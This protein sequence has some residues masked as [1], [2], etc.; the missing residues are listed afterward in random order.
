MRTAAVVIVFAV[1][2]FTRAAVGADE[3]PIT[4]DMALR[5]V[6]GFREADPRSDDALGYAAIAL[7]FVR[8]DKKLQFTL[9]P[10]NT[11]FVAAK[12]LSQ[13]Q[14]SLLLGA[15]TVGNLQSCL[16]RGDRTD[17]PYAGDLQVIQTYRQ[18]QKGQPRLRIPEIE[19]LIE[20]EDRG[21]L[22]KYV[23]SP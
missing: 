19:K 8:K 15:Y 1:A 6:A 7:E 18:M 13:Q 20:L 12:N 4:K 11:S 21:E 2:L 10:K 14:R 17:D 5:A 23:S 16:L 9:T 22:R 3:R